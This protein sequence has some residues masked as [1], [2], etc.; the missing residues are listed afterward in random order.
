MIKNWRTAQ[1]E[2]IIAERE[3]RTLR[4]RN[5]MKRHERLARGHHKLKD[6][7]RTRRMDAL[8]AS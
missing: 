1:Q 2:R 8:K 6:D 4:N 5:A 3:M 7:D